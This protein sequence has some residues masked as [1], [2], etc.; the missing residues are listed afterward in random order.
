MGNFIGTDGTGATLEVRDA[1][2]NPLASNDDWQETQQ[3]EIQASDK[4]PPGPKEFAIIIE[5]PPA[6]ITAI[7]SG[8]KNTTGNTLV[9]ST[10]SL[11]SRKP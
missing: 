3:A 10:S 5:R 8:K 2:G 4:A 6:N 1:Q 7:V 9:K 11:I